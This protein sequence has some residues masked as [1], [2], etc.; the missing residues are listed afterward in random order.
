MV[1]TGKLH[2]SPGLWSAAA[3][4]TEAIPAETVAICLESALA[5]L[6][7]RGVRAARPGRRTFCR[8]EV[9]FVEKRVKKK[10]R[11]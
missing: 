1:P 5:G 6:A 8:G 11:V 7:M 9:Y 2:N 4:P 10:F 3:L